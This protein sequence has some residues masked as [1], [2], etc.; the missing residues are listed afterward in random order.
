MTSGGYN[1]MA[2]ESYTQGNIVR[3]TLSVRRQSTLDLGL[4][5]G[6]YGRP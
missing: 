2:S 3:Q 1:R 6:C 5:R 4:E